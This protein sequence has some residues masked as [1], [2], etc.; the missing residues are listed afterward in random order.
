MTRLVNHTPRPPARFSPVPRKC[1]RFDGWTDEKQREFIVTLAATGS[2]RAAAASVNMSESG[3]IALRKAQGA[4][5]F[6]RAWGKAVTV[7][8]A[9]IREVMVDHALNGVPEPVFYAGKQVGERR[10]F[11]LRT[12]QFLLE[13]GAAAADARTNESGGRMPT[14]AE[15]AKTRHRLATMIGKIQ[16]GAFQSLA[17]SIN[18]DEKRAAFEVLFGAK[19]N[20]PPWCF[21]T[22]PNFNTVGMY[23]AAATLVDGG[24]L[25]LELRDKLKAC[26]EIAENGGRAKPISDDA[27]GPPPRPK[28]RETANGPRW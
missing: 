25:L 10:R 5:S 28:P 7:A 8:A 19:L 11:N 12:Q 2:L 16:D 18:T 20:E 15:A 9:R 22:D 13:K 6:S 23:G 26:K 14:R 21:G 17:Q 3:A 1:S 4:A 27:S 24:A